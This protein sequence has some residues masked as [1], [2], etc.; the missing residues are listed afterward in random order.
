MFTG[1]VEA[2]G[3][4]V[5]SA[6]TGGG[7]RVR[8]ATALGP[9]L[10]LG[11]SVAVNGVCL[12]VIEHDADGM[13]MDIGPETLRV[14][15]L[16]G[17]QPGQVVNL[18]RSVRADSRFGGHFV[19]GHVD[20]VGRI[21]SV[22]PD[23]EFHTVTVE[24]P[25]SFAANIIHRGSI[26]VDGISLTVAGLS[27]NRFELMIIPFTMAHTN[28]RQAVAGTPVNLEFDVVGKYVARAAEVAREQARQ[29]NG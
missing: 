23:V 22:V 25:S 26:A 27:G 19:Q 29:S 13:R 12:T 21:V 16:G 28:L 20:A 8:L 9:E 6:P 15:T 18:E 11:E 17:L 4:I 5:E 7:V 3:E 2:V 1:L 10:T 14:T 24:F